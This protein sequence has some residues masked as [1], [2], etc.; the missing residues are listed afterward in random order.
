MKK[1]YSLV[2]F[3]G[4]E[5]AKVEI[6]KKYNV[7]EVKLEK[8]EKDIYYKILNEINKIDFEKNLKKL[9]LKNSFSF[10]ERK[11]KY[12]KLSKFEKLKIKYFIYRD[13]F[14]FG[15]IE[16]ILNDFNV[17]YLICKGIIF[18]VFVYH[19]NYGFLE[20]NVK[21]E[22][23]YEY[24]KVIENLK[25]KG[26]EINGKIEITPNQFSITKIERPPIPLN[27]LVKLKVL[28][29]DMANYLN[30]VIKEGLSI[31]VVGENDFH[32]SVIINSLALTVDKEVKTVTFEKVPRLAIKQKLWYQRI[33]SVYKNKENVIETMLRLGPKLVIADGINELSQIVKNIKNCQTFISIPG[34]SI[35]DAITKLNEIL[36][37]HSISLIDV[38]LTICDGKD[39]W[40]KIEGVYEISKYD[41]EKEMLRIVKIF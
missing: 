6:N 26:G 14:G 1:S 11:L 25:I 4:Y 17:N 41:A 22:T 3:N 12:F 40:P 23:F 15:K 29:K 18:P 37:V 28:K 7:K 16:P 34:K 36:P 5:L 32:R 21:F 13:Y 31:L 24:N 9:N 20:T 27:T 30:K 38:I 2:T 8:E 35:D 33:L 39:G 10:I 19:K